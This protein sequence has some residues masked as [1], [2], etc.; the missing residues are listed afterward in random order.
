MELVFSIDLNYI[1]YLM[2]F[3]LLQIP[4]LK[5]L[6]QS[7]LVLGW[8]IRF[9][10]ILNQKMVQTLKIREPIDILDSGSKRQD[11]YIIFVCQRLYNGLYDYLASFG[12]G[13][14]VIIDTF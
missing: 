13:D 10:N 11:R 9:F 7:R 5:N 6:L 14:S 4:N 8:K 12:S 1:N 3:P 2:D